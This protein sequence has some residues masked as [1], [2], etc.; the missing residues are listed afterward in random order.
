M[1]DKETLKTRAARGARDPYTR[2]LL[3]GLCILAVLSFLL[4]VVAG[5]LAWKNAHDDAVAGRD[6]AQQ[7]LDA[8]QDN[9]K[10]TADVQALCEKAVKVDQGTAGPTGAHGEQGPIGLTG[11]QG[12]IGPQGPVGPEGPRGFTGVEGSTGKTG[13]DGATGDPGAAGPPG[14]AGSTGPQGP[15]GPP[16]PA[17]PQGETGPQGPQGERGPDGPAGYP[18]SFTFQIGPQTYTCTDPDNDHNYDCQPSGPQ[19]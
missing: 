10:D 15:A 1:V 5:S 2:R 3:I 4:A 13:A 17:G 8:C 6:L 14:E 18:Q 11:P 16:G 12:P 19:P 7:V 9:Q